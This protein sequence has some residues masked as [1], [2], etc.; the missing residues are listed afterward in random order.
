MVQLLLLEGRILNP[1]EG[2]IVSSRSRNLSNLV[3]VHILPT[4]KAQGSP[5]VFVPSVLRSNVMSI[6][7]KI[8]EIR[9]VLNNLN[10]DVGCF[11]ET[12]LQEHISDQTVSAA[13]YNLIRRDRCVGQ[14]GGVCAYVRKIIKYQVLE[15]LFDARFEVLWLTLR[16]SR[17]PRGIPNIILGV[18]YHP[19]GADCPSMVQYLYECLTIIES[20][21]PNSGTILLGDFNKLKVSRIQN[22]FNLKQ[23]VKFPTRGRN[24]LDLLLTD[25]DKFYDSPRKLPPFGLSDHDSIFIPPLSQSQ[26]PNPTC[27]TKS[28][29]LRPTKRSALTR[30]LEE[31]N[32]NQLVNNETSCDDKA[33]TFEMI[34]NNGLDA[35][36]PII[37]KVIIT[38]EPPW[39]SS[40]FKKLIRNRQKAFTWG[41]LMTFRKLRNQVN[42]ERKKLCA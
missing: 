1:H 32:I 33:K 38:N 37:E 23:V 21:F 16:A 17:L 41:D 28:R 24:I 26:V 42:R 11:V 6:A 40:S 12:W 39:V 34:I 9:V 27:R 3:K 25:L 2:N 36:A 10:V 15:N 14:H 8:D 20:E 7:P 18:V 29:Q 19:P 31:V 35:I 13:G 22:A 5:T 4:A 30:Y